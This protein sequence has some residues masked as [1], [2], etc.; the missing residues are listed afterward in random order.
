MSRKRGRLRAPRVSV[1]EQFERNWWFFAVVLLVS[2]A[3]A[4][5]FLE[6]TRCPYQVVTDNFLAALIA[7]AGF[8]FPV[9][10][11]VFSD[12]KVTIED[13]FAG[14][15][16]VVLGVGIMVAALVYVYG[17]DTMGVAISIAPVI[18]L[19]F[20]LVLMAGV[21]VRRGG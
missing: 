11:R 13:A 12:R 14:F 3:V 17:F 18:A 9:L 2:V 5:L 4:I 1:R 15:L 8:V 19:G 7:M 20:L 10:L 6:P 21:G 16:A